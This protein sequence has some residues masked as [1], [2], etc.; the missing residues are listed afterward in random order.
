MRAWSIITCDPVLL[1]PGKDVMQHSE[2]HCSCRTLVP[3]P[4]WAPQHKIKFTCRWWCLGKTVLIFRNK[5]V[6]ITVTRSKDYYI[7]WDW[8]LKHAFCNRMQVFIGKTNVKV[9]L[10]IQLFILKQLLQNYCKVLTSVKCL[11]GM[12][13]SYNSGG[14]GSVPILLT[15]VLSG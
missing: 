7:N 10:Y 6:P 15:Y 3:Q 14:V 5:P 13:W 2:Q 12:R 11:A 9:S 8:I 1:L 4:E